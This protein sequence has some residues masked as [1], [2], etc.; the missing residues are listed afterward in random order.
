MK[1]SKNRSEQF[2]SKPVLSKV[3]GVHKAQRTRQHD[4]QRL[5]AVQTNLQVMSN[6]KR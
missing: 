1:T 3:E 5:V 2:E 4:A 6:Q